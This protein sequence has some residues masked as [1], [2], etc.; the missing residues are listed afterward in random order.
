MITP[1]RVWCTRHRSTAAIEATSLLTL[2]QMIES[3]LGIGLVP[4]MAVNAGLIDSPTLATRPFAEPAPKRT[5]ALVTRRS[6]AR[7]D[8]F[9]ALAEVFRQRGAACSGL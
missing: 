4:E 2:V 9:A 8:E 6:T 3:G 1:L 7:A 5:V